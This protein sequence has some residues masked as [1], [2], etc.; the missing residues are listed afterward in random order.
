V[1]AAVS[2]IATIDCRLAAYEWP[3]RRDRAADIDAH[4]AKRCAAAPGLFDGRVLLMRDLEVSA[5]RLTCSCFE[6]PYRAF[7]A[8]RDFGYPG[9]PVVNCFGMAALESSDG[10]F[11]LGRMAAG[12]ATA[13]RLYFPAGTPE[14]ADLDADSRVDFEANVRRELAEETGL[15]APEAQFG[16]GW[17]LVRTAAMAALMKQV[18]VPVSASALRDHQSRFN[19]AQHAARQ[20]AELADLVP[21]ASPAEYDRGAMPEFMILYLDWAFARRPDRG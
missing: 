9:P 19:A 4:W 3:F 12:T 1:T 7:L 20:E 13:G 2:A 21:I 18:R 15:G 11:L 16:Q 8:W 10:A 5:D 17:T 14:P 6:A